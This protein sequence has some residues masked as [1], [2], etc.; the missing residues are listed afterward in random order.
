[1][2]LV[3][4]SDFDGLVCAALLQ[5]LHL[6][7]EILYTHPKDIQDKKVSVDSNDIL[8]NVPYAEGCGLWFDHHSSEEE[9]LHLSGKYKGL[10]EKAPSAA[11][12]IYEYYKSKN[13]T[14]LNK[15]AEM[16][17]AVNKSDSAQYTKEDI[18]NPKGWMLLAFLTD[19][20]T[21]LGYHHGFSISNFELMKK[22]PDYLQTMSINE[23][24]DLQ[25][26]KARIKVYT[27]ETEKY[28]KFIKEY[29]RNE[30]NAVIIDLR[31]V[32]DKAIGN[33]FVEYT[34]YP[35]QNISIRIID[36]RGKE[37]VMISVGKSIINRTSPLDVGSLMLGYNGGGHK[38][39][40]TCQVQYSEVEKVLGELLNVINK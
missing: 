22:M 39:V 25:D 8:A 1:M 7:D 13:D 14:R 27:E 11:Q 4:R 21:G 6:V 31:G 28:I 32:E 3:T 24:L 12:V 29:S 16:I 40:G 18:T 30:G 17:Q 33:R 38:A 20:R 10:S 9:R 2:R 19:P 36:G 23:I 35:E 5:E 34:I 15:F 37:F 26:V